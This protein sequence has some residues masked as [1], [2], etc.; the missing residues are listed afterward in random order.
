MPA[1]PKRRDVQ[2]A[3]QASNNN[4]THF[5][6]EIMILTSEKILEI[7][8]LIISNFGGTDG[9]LC[10]GTIDYLVDQVNAQQDLFRQAAIALH[11]VADRHPFLDG[12][13]RSAFQIAELILSSEGYFITAKEEEIIEV[14]L[15]IASSQCKTISAHISAKRFIS[16]SLRRML[17]SR[18]S[19]S[20]GLRPSNSSADLSAVFVDLAG[21]SDTIQQKA[22]PD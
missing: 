5:L 2:R 10:Q 21:C 16:L 20:L 19:L 9:V 3:L 1:L 13:K 22:C 14:L 15:K 7:H 12:N 11:I 18:R 6:V 17:S 8:Q 4:A